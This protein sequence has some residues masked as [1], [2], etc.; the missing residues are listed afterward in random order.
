MNRYDWWHAWKG[1]SRAKFI[2]NILYIPIIFVYHIPDHAMQ[3]H[4]N[5]KTLRHDH[6]HQLSNQRPVKLCEA[7]HQFHPMPLGIEPVLYTTPNRQPPSPYSKG[8]APVLA[9]PPTHLNCAKQANTHPQSS[10]VLDVD[11][12]QT[13]LLVVVNVQRESAKIV[14]LFSVC[15][16]RQCQEIVGK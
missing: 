11:S 14:L 8:A 13:A 15:T 1:A 2:N 16:E 10:A 3:R 6:V 5:K 12:H 7:F 4:W 9:H